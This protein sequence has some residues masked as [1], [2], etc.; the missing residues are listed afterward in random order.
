MDEIFTWSKFLS[1]S[2]NDLFD[3]AGRLGGGE[4]IQSCSDIKGPSENSLDLIFAFAS[5]YD[6]LQTCLLGSIEFYMN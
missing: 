2:E 1:M 4:S 3:S 5:S 6:V